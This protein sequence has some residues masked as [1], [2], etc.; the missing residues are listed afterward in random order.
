MSQLCNQAPVRSSTQHALIIRELILSQGAVV[1]TLAISVTDRTYD[2]VSGIHTR[3][4][5]G[6]HLWYANVCEEL[7]HSNESM[8]S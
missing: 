4:Q 5:F 1:Y 3:L 8:L 7:E 2:I 6:R